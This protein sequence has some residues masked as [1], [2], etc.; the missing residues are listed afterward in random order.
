METTG[1]RLKM[2]LVGATKPPIWRRM[3]IPGKTTFYEL[4]LI[5]QEVMT[6]FDY[7]LYEFVMPEFFTTNPEVLE[8]YGTAH[9]DKQFVDPYMTMVLGFFLSYQK[10]DY[11]YDFGDGWQIK[12]QFEDLV[13][14]DYYPPKVLAFKGIS[15]PEDC[16][17]LGGFE[18]LKAILADSNHEDHQEMLAWSAMQQYDTFDID[19]VNG[20]L[21]DLF[22][23][24]GFVHL[25]NP[26]QETAQDWD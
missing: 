16:G 24:P 23:D 12:L 14:L 2:Q 11:R 1:I 10:I 26:F 4:H 19:E 18:E 8:D 25:F 20:I 6:W 17:G 7:H 21:E 9:R 15:P 22:Q 5:I 3:T 13:E